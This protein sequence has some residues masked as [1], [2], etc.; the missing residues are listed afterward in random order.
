MSDTSI[1]H[2]GFSDESYYEKGR[3]R[4]LALVTLEDES[5]KTVEASIKSLLQ[6]SG[7]REF[8]WK[9]LDSAKSRFAALKIIDYCVDLAC[10]RKLRVDVLVWDTQDSRHNIIGRD[11]IQNL[12]RMYYHLFRNVLRRRWSKGAK[13][14]LYPDENTALDWNQLRGYLENT[15]WSMHV[16]PPS[17]FG[18]E[19]FRLQ[20]KRE[21]GLEQIEAGVSHERPL[22]Q[23]ADLFAGLAVFS[24]DK[25]DSY[26]MWLNQR[27]LQSDLFNTD[28]AQVS[29]SNSERERFEVLRHF[30]GL[31][32]RHGLGVSLKSHQ[33]LRTP[34]PAQPLNF[35]FY[36]PQHPNDKAPTRQS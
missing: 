17:L 3:F 18:P 7:V 22:L 15:S 32:K 34:N 8:K 20:L 13:W 31:C 4:S 27:S 11:D 26:Q 21:F 25:F 12:Q 6:E 30:D 29:A 14:R 9:R 35:W 33:G 36:E 19:G 10:Q 23:V 24:R 28:C 2:V 16:D 5:L 1:T